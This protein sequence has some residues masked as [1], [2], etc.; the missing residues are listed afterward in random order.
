MSS[1]ENRPKLDFRDNTTLCLLH[2][3]NLQ[4]LLQARNYATL[5]LLEER[6]AL[7]RERYYIWLSLLDRYRLIC[8]IYQW[9]EEL[10]ATRIEYAHNDFITPPNPDALLPYT[11]LPPS[12]ESPRTIMPLR[13]S[14]PPCA[15]YPV[16]VSE[17]LCFI[18]SS[19][20]TGFRG[21]R[22]MPLHRLT[23]LTQRS[24]KSKQPCLMWA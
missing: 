18:V 6:N 17:P 13:A 15:Y 8:I 22:S 2:E 7:L 5:Q 3:A 12:P 10:G 11:I 4:D 14:R 24:S 9:R 21:N 1:P 20:L 16:D 19:Q 23:I